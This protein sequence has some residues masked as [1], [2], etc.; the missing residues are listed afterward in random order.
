MLETVCCACLGLGRSVKVSPAETAAL[1]AG[2]IG[3]RRSR[4]FSR[5]RAAWEHLEGVFKLGSLGS[6]PESPISQI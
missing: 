1:Q 4:C 2:A 3:S 6:P 5:R